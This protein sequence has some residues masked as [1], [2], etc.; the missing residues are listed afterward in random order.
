ML[1]APG[2]LAGGAA[3]GLVMGPLLGGAQA[4]VLRAV[5]RYPW[6]WVLANTVAWPLVMVVIFYGATRPGA[7]WS[8]SAVVLLGAGTGAAAAGAVLGFLTWWWLPAVDGVQASAKRG[9]GN[10][11]E[12]LGVDP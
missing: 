10:G 8:A 4:L 11:G 2:V 6:R 3:I 1:S 7:D 5:V 9:L 12:L